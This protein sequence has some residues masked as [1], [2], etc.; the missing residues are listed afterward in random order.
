L[1]AAVSAAPA[2]EVPGEYRHEDRALT[3]YMIPRTPQQ[4]AA[5]YEARGFPVEARELIR[6]AC[7]ITT[8]IQNKRDGVLWLELERWRF[9]SERGAVQRI[10]RDFWRKQWAR[11]DLPQAKR[12]TFEWTL[13]PEI[14]DLQPGEPVGANIVLEPTREP[15]TVEARFKTARDKAGPEITVRLENV[16]CAQDRQP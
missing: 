15:F 14:R 6:E 7:F 11:L 3:L 4:M 2:A 9:V 16:R 12:S 5:F 13:M 1:L 8:G 10:R